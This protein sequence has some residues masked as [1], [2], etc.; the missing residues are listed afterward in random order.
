MSKAP[1][2]W[3]LLG[4]LETGTCILYGDPNNL[5]MNIKIYSNHLNLDII[6]DMSMLVIFGQLCRPTH[7]SI[8]QPCDLMVALV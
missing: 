1:T 7:H 6:F 8:G 2:R 5:E 3:L 4:L